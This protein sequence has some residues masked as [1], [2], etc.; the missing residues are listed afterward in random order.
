MVEGVN[1][2]GVLSQQVKLPQNFF[3]TI[4]Q[5]SPRVQCDQAEQL[6]PPPRRTL[7][8]RPWH[9]PRTSVHVRWASQG[10]RT[11]SNEQPDDGAPGGRDEGAT[12]R[13]PAEGPLTR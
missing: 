12:T 2:G 3:P 13:L 8:L 1:F 4:G 10:P 6:M 9:P 7:P 5:P 11:V